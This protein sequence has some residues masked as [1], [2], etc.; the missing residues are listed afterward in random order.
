MLRRPVV[1]NTW[2]IEA[3]RCI[4]THNAEHI[5]HCMFI[6]WNLLLWGDA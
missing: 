4:I 2:T 1:R 6:K 5:A 3:K